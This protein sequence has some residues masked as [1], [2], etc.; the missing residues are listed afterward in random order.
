[1][2]RIA[3]LLPVERLVGSASL[4]RER[5]EPAHSRTPRSIGCALDA[6]LRGDTVA[7]RLQREAAMADDRPKQRSELSLLVSAEARLDG[8]LAAARAE[9]T[10]VMEA[11]RRR[12]E[13]A[14]AALAEEIATRAARIAADSAAE[15]T[16]QRTA[17]AD[18]AC[19]EIARYEAVR[20]EALSAL[21]AA[22]VAKLAAIARA[23]A[24]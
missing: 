19:T 6:A 3:S 22:V 15:V 21:V 1:M 4:H 10:A 2:Q 13:A 9:A 5:A 24:P 20:G 12:A 18:A 14:D 11:A 16:R 17:I 8:A 23:E 7:C